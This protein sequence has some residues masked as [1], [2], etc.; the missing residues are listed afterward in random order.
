MLKH[1]LSSSSFELVVLHQLRASPPA[2]L[3]RPLPLMGEQP[4]FQ[5]FADFSLVLD[6]EKRIFRLQVFSD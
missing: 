5:D 3:L 1:T 4:I 2:A 6:R